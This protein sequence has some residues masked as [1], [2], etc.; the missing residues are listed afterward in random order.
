MADAPPDIDGVLAFKRQNVA[1]ERF[2]SIVHS[3]PPPLPASP[4]FA[5]PLVQDVGF[6]S[7]KKP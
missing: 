2:Y 1:K 4:A 3:P 7:I 5:H 6:T